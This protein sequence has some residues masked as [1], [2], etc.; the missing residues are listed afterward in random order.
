MDLREKKTKRSIT[1]AFIELRSKKP[2]ERITVKELSELAQISKATFY[3]HYKDIYDLSEK[4]QNEVI[5]N[6]LG[7]IAHPE[8]CLADN[9]LFTEELFC[10][11]YAQ[12]TL[13]D[14]LFSG[15]QNAILSM[16][17][18]E[19][20]LKYVKEH[21]P[22]MDEKT[23]MLLTYMINGAYC[24]YQKYSKTYP[25]DEIIGFV[26]NVSNSILLSYTNV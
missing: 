14:K 16:R 21:N 9:K 18:E 24:V 7:G 5:Q 3:L 1:N 25:S 26:G 12:Q 2:L 15:S 10:A 4:L 8:Y 23:E 11:F 6:I 19:E 17:L 20:L 22:R 13:I